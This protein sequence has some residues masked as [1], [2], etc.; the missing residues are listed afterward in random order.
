MLV[1]EHAKSIK[2]IM[3]LFS[4]FMNSI[5]GYHLSKLCDKHSLYTQII[6]GIYQ[7]LA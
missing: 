3:G 7:N 2:T 5:Y 1:T 4:T 6:Q